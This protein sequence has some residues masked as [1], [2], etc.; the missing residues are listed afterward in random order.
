MAGIQLSKILQSLNLLVAVLVMVVSVSSSAQTVSFVARTDLL[1]GQG[2]S[3][4]AT[5]DLNADSKLDLVIS[6]EFS[7]SVSVLLGN[8]DG[9]FQPAVSYPVG[10]D[11]IAVSIGISMETASW[12]FSR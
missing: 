7:N 6:N 11:P 2:P 1:V 12:I 9:T 8:G 10:A 4:V 5:A 3:A